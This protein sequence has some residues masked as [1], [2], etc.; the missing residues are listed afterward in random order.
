MVPTQQ[1]TKDDM[2]RALR[3]VVNPFI[4]ILNFLSY[5]GHL[6]IQGIAYKAATER[7]EKREYERYDFEKND[8]KYW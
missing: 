1:Y 7:C 3:W 6:E 4:W 5:I 2:K 8:I